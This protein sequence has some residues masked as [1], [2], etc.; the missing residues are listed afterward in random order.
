MTL[1]QTIVPIRIIDKKKCRCEKLLVVVLSSQRFPGKYMLLLVS[2]VVCR[3]LTISSYCL[4]HDPLGYMD[5]ISRTLSLGLL[6]WGAIKNCQGRETIN[7]HM[8]LCYPMNCNNNQH[9][10]WYWGI[11][12][13]TVVVLMLAV[14][15]NSLTWFRISPI[16]GKSCLILETYIA[17]QG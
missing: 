16:L 3:K 7:I 14:I 1:G 6:F 13:G 8:Q 17:T 12:I 9:P 5:L 11:P 2:L 4:R 15:R 10:Y